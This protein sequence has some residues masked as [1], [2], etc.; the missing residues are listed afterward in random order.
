KIDS[1]EAHRSYERFEQGEQV[2]GGGLDTQQNRT[3]A[4]VVA[5]MAAFLALA[6]FLSDEAVKHV[7]TEETHSAATTAKLESNAVKIGLAQGNAVTLRVL[8]A[9]TQLSPAAAA[10]AREHDNQV[11]NKLQP[12]AERLERAI[13]S[14]ARDADHADTQH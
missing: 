6:M 11:I 1:V 8:G 4:L 12:A 14:H 5:V 7:I 9:G 3:A 10:A 13:E 2:A